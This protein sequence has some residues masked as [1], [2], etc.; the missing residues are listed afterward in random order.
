M[1][2]R[3]TQL[4]ER[5]DALEL[6]ERALLFI[7][8]LFGFGMLWQQLLLGPMEMEQ[9]QMLAQIDRLHQEVD[10]LDRE[11]Q[12]IIERANHDPDAENRVLLNRYQGRDA[13]LEERILD[14]V[15]GLI[16]PKQMARMVEQVLQGRR[17]LT[18]VS[19]QSLPATP[20][21]ELAD[22]EMMEGEGIFRHGLRLQ[23]EGD[24][25]AAL[26]YLKALEALPWS[27]K[28][29]A[30][31]VE[32]QEYPRALITITVYTLSLEEDWLGV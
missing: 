11:Y 2:E 9:K 24:Y 6:R 7:T 20:L 22:E 14:S 16:D 15:A 30:V 27:L 18:L 23:L 4:L 17:A 12:A 10:K 8:V 13:E 3:W 26:D 31:E 28:W 21:L 19:M 29:D 1:K 32:M 5:I 25:L